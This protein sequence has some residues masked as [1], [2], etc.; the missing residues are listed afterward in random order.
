MGKEIKVSGY[1][2][3]KQHGLGNKKSH[4]TIEYCGDLLTDDNG[5]VLAFDTEEDA[6]GYIEDV[7]DTTVDGC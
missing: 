7:M 2:V 6:A 1:A 3:T 4:Y 5:N